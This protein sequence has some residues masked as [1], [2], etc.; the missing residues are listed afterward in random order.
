MARNRLL[1]Q[2]AT[3]NINAAEQR[4]QR[5]NCHG[6][7]KIPGQRAGLAIANRYDWTVLRGFARQPQDGVRRM[8]GAQDRK[9]FLR[10]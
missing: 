6:G 5:M 8:A 4:V 10:L 7:V 2:D 1:H 9:G 3:G